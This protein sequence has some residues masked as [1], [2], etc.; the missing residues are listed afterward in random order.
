VHHDPVFRGIP[1]RISPE[2]PTLLG[3]ADEI[4]MRSIQGHPSQ[5]VA[6]AIQHCSVNPAWM[7]GHPHSLPLDHKST[8]ASELPDSL[9]VHP[10]LVGNLACCLTFGD[11]FNDKRTTLLSNS[12][13]SRIS[14]TMYLPLKGMP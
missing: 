9:R 13:G 14:H 11:Q 10:Q 3:S 7:Q 4:A 8:V 2:K 12:A 1:V 6:T 5:Q